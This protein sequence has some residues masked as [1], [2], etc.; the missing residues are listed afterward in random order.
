VV[1]VT[2]DLKDFGNDL[3]LAFLMEEGVDSVN[4]GGRVGVLHDD[5][6]IAFIKG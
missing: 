6:P 2:Y 1:H 3:I 5:T 4:N